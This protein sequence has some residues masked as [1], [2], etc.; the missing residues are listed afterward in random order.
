MNENFKK[1]KT[2]Q[3][4]IDGKVYTLYVADDHEKRVKG[5]SGIPY[6]NKQEGMLF[7]Y[8]E[9]VCHSYTM[10]STNFPLR[11]IFL[12][13]NLNTVGSFSA[14]PG[15]KEEIRPMSDFKYVIEVLEK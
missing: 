8:E 2:V 11:I 10:E 9:P 14:K 3:V 1:Y 12:D 13:E 4:P 7:K 6:I 15:Q 5:L